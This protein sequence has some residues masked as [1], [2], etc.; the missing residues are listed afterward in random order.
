MPKWD[1]DKLDQEYADWLDTECKCDIQEEGCSCPNFDDWFDEKLED[2]AES[3]CTE[4]QY[5]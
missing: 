3:L 2:Y 1:D 5:A 4:E